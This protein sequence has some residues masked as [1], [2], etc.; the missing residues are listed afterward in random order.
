MRLDWISKRMRDKDFI[1]D[2]GLHTQR[3]SVPSA[4]RLDNAETCAVG[5]PSSICQPAQRRAGAVGKSRAVTP[6]PDGERELTT[7][8]AAFVQEYLVDLNATQAAIRAGYAPESAN[9]EGSRLLTRSNVRQAIETGKAQRLSRVNTSQDSV[10]HELS[11][12]AMSSV[13]HYVVDDDGQVQ[14]ADGAPTGAMR[15]VQS[16]RR[17]IRTRTD[18]DGN[19]YRTVDV[20]IKL[21]DKPMP[22]KLMGRHVGL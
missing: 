6:R 14:L 2:V 5:G 10:L 18:R 12:L 16:I 19:R 9:V 1:S 3:S 4:R 15:A 13:A 17:R 21:W 20:E 11:L 8:Q 7:R 22:L